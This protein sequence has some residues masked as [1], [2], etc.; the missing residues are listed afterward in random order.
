VAAA[1]EDLV[2]DA[3]RLP[4]TRF[5]ASGVRLELAACLP[6][7]YGDRARLVQVFASL[8]DH[9][10]RFAAPV[11]PLVTIE[12]RASQDGMATLV[13]RDNGAAFDGWDGGRGPD[14]FEKLD[15]RTGGPGVG[16]AAAKRVVESHG[17]RVWLE[18]AGTGGGVSVCLTLPLPPEGDSAAVLAREAAARPRGSASPAEERRGT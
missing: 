5:S 18:A 1:V 17:G 16:L 2:R 9:A 14:P 7:V 11:D 6:P 15:S 4:G 13:V 12:A 8:L 10:A 3:L